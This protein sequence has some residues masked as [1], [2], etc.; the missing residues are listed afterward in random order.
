MNK[1]SEDNKLKLLYQ[2]FANVIT[3]GRCKYYRP[4]TDRQEGE[5]NYGCCTLLYN[6][7]GNV[8]ITVGLTD[9]CSF[10]DKK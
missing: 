3:C 5:D 10:A 7:G 2:G 4:L 9:Y 1:K 6:K 8:R